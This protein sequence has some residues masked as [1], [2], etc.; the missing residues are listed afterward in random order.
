MLG[1]LPGGSGRD[2]AVADACLSDQVLGSWP[3]AGFMAALRA[4]RPAVLIQ[5]AEQLHQAKKRLFQSI[6]NRSKV[7]A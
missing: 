7:A 2:E 4:P 6:H 3:S 1:S 5:A